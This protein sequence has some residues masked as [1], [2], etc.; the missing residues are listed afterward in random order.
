MIGIGVLAAIGRSV[1][2][3]PVVTSAVV[4]GALEAVVGGLA[5]IL[6]SLR[7][8]TTE[9][10]PGVRVLDL[11]PRPFDAVGRAATIGVSGLAV[12]GTRATV[13][14]LQAG[15]L[16]KSTLLARYIP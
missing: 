1:D 16:H 8:P 2:S 9:D 6:W 14:M 10:V 13:R 4:S 3:S 5:G 12:R 15:G 11:L 7:R